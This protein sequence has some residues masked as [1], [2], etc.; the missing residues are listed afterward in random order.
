Q[1]S[2]GAGVTDR[3]AVGANEGIALAA[4]DATDGELVLVAEGQAVIGGELLDRRFDNDRL[5][6]FDRLHRQ[7]TEHFGKSHSGIGGNGPRS[8][9][10][11]LIRHDAKRLAPVVLSALPQCRRPWARSS[12]AI[13]ARAG[14]L[15]GQE[16]L[17]ESQ[18][19]HLRLPDTFHGCHS[20]DNVDF[21]PSGNAKVIAIRPS[22]RSR[23][24]RAAG[25]I[26]RKI[27]PRPAAINVSIR[28]ACRRSL[29]GRIIA[30]T[31]K[32]ASVWGSL[33]AL[34]GG[35]NVREDL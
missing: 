19:S 24:G 2:D 32:T 26:P 8:L 15:G 28:R 23:R 12:R 9:E 18:L 31:M 16:P 21:G 14:H 7:L 10:I 1:A 13:R 6:L 30:L 17:G 34:R 3:R 22:D 35:A 29:R 20:A 25:L 4:L 33:V 27:G 11:L 5:R